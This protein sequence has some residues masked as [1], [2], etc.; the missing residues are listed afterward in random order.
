MFN[1]LKVEIKSPAGF[2]FAFSPSSYTN[3]PF[4]WSN[5]WFSLLKME[6]KQA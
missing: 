5:Q 2:S 6:V 3:E 4:S 1:A